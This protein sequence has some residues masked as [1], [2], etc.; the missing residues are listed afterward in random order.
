MSSGVRHDDGLKARRIGAICVEKGLITKAQLDAALAAQETSGQVLG[1]ILVGQ[2]SM[3]RMQL[4][5]VLGEQWDEL[6]AATTAGEPDDDRRELRL[7]LEEAQAARAHLTQLSAELGGRLTS[8]E[9]LVAGVNERLGELQSATVEGAARSPQKART[10]VTAAKSK[11]PT[12][13]ARVAA[14]E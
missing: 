9:K 8:L 1:E 13:R 6:T 4:A 10:R 11:A 14:K 12:R 2:D 3:T 7:L 5:D